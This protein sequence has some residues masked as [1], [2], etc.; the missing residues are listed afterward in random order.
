MNTQHNFNAANLL[1]RTG[2][3]FG[4]EDRA[5]VTHPQSMAEVD[6]VGLVERSKTLPPN[7]TSSI[8]VGLRGK[9]VLITGSGAGLG[10]AHAL[11][12]AK[13]GAIVIINY[14]NQPL[15]TTKDS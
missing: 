10:K 12:F 5:K 6:W 15:K 3:I 13:E 11:Q 9:I 1:Q 7:P 14:I 8:D 2:E 4:F